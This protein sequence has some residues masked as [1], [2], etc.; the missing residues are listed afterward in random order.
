M[1]GKLEE[2]KDYLD[3]HPE[4]L[5]AIEEVLA[6]ITGAV[7]DVKIKVDRQDPLAAVFEGAK[8][9]KE[10]QSTEAQAREVANLVG[11]F[12]L[13]ALKTLL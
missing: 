10:G 7:R 12:L 3:K 11:D 6:Q 9:L 13:Q 5:P 4:I 8:A 2:I 1:P